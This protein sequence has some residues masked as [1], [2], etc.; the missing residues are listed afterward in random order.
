[1]AALIEG[2]EIAVPVYDFVAYVRESRTHKLLASQFVLV[3]GLFA[4][5]WDDVRRLARTKVF[6]EAADEICLARRLERDI[7]ER[8]RTVETVIEQY[9]ATVRPMA[10]LYLRPTRAF[11]DVTVSGCEPLDLSLQMVLKHVAANLPEG[12]AGIDSARV[13]HS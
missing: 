6:V 8:G 3:E 1:L 12:A 10:D 4:L 7:R 9:A 2:A 11:A 5:Y 13:A